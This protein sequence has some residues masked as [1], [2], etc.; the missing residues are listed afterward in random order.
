MVEEAKKYLQDILGRVNGLHCILIT[1]RDGVRMLKVSNDKT[2]EQANKPNFISTFGLAIDQGSKLGLGKT[3]T[4]ICTYS[5]YQVVQMNKLPLIV[6]F[7]ASD[8]CNTGHI[9]ALEKQI[10]GIVSD[11]A[12]AVT[13]S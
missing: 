8:S 7:I 9:L 3:T 1:D 11:L 6:T 2:P 5:Q 12:L 4:L 10:D 13:E